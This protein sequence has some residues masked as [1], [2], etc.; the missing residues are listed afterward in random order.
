MLQFTCANQENIMAKEIEGSVGKRIKTLRT[1]KGLALRAL[2]LRCGMSANAISLIE[3]GENSPTVSSLHR[4]ATALGVPITEFFQAE[5]ATSSVYV[6]PGQGMWIQNDDVKLESLGYG[7]PHQQLE[8][9][10]MIVEPGGDSCCGA[11][12]HT[13]EEFIYCISGE[14]E[15]YVD[16]NNYHLKAGSS[17]LLDASHPHGWRSINDKPAVIL[18]IF[19]AVQDS[20]SA[21][22]QHLELN[23]SE[24]MRLEIENG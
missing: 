6:A 20:N 18:L 19:Q 23:T 16:E 14:L 1:E 10:R 17:L 9:F 24:T 2:A 13:G 3:R 7:L 5:Q 11:I 12:S 15:Y 21:R 8:P 4:L 22:Q